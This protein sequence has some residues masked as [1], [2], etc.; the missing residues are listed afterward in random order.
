MVQIYEHVYVSN[1]SDNSK[2]LL[3]GFI[4]VISDILSEFTSLQYFNT[5]VRTPKPSSQLKKRKKTADFKKL[6]VRYV[7]A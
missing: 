2:K 1:V 6:S 7:L 5:Y 4:P 3:I